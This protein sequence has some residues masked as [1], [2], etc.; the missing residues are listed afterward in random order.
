MMYTS[1]SM[2]INVSLGV[3]FMMSTASTTTWVLTLLGTKTIVNVVTAGG[4]ASMVTLA[5]S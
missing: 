4:P 1:S 3:A 5:S 2:T